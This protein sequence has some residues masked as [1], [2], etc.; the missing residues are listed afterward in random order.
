M[1]NN[2]QQQLCILQDAHSVTTIRWRNIRWW[3]GQ[4]ITTVASAKPNFF[5]ILNDSMRDHLK[6]LWKTLWEFRSA[7]LLS[8][9]L[10]PTYFNRPSHKPFVRTPQKSRVADEYQ[11]QP[12]C[13]PCF[14]QSPAPPL[15]S[16]W[17]WP[18]HHVVKSN[19]AFGLRHSS[20][21]EWFPAATLE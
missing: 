18:T 19:R 20:R 9:H 17:P 4:G 3:R 10:S 2:F 5:D 15:Q 6:I 21:H 11:I 14:P 16:I 7:L 13:L 8:K 1:A 12:T